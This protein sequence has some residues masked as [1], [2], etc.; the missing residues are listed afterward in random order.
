METFDWEEKKW[1]RG[2]IQQT[3]DKKE[4]QWMGCEEGNKCLNQPIKMV[5]WEPE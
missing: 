2:N 4:S 3:G 1:E 5:I